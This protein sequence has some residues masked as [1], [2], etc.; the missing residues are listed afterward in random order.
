[1]ALC[2]VE[3]TKH[4]VMEPQDYLEATVILILVKMVEPVLVLLLDIHVHV[5][6]DLQA[7]PVQHHQFQHVPQTHVKTEVVAQLLPDKLFVLVLKDGLE[8][9]VQFQTIVT[10][11]HVPQEH[12]LVLIHQTINIH[13]HHHSH[14][15]V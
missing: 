9:Y 3:T 4:Y 12:L 8:H 13:L 6:M 14:A 11:L 5:L 7:Q 1:M 10:L 2:S 15:I